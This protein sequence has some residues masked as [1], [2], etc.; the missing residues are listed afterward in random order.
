MAA[1]GGSGNNT[2]REGVT[3]KIRREVKALLVDVVHASLE[4][5]PMGTVLSGSVVV[6]T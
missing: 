4:G 3:L 6:F 2:K 1:S 5:L